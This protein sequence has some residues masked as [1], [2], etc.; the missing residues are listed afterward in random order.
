MTFTSCKDYVKAQQ[1]MIMSPENR[2]YTGEKVGHDPTP[3][4]LF[5]NW[6]QSGAAKQFGIKNTLK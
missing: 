6:I 3:N 2:W 1:A 5:W 4:E